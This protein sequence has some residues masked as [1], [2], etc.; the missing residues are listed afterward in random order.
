MG[1]QVL[2]PGFTVAG[3]MAL[4]EA[5]A[6]R[7]NPARPM[8]ITDHRPLA[9]LLVAGDGAAAVH[10]VFQNVVSQRVAELGV[11]SCPVGPSRIQEGLHFLAGRDQAAK[12]F[13][14]RGGLQLSLRKATSSACRE[15]WVPNTQ[16]RRGR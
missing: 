13:A 6:V 15:I 14:D 5:V 9:G 8:G 11:K 7:V 12:K 1:R 16:P 10:A 4:G 2:L 3:L